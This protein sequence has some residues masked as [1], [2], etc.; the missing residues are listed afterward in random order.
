MSRMIHFFLNMFI[1]LALL[2]TSALAHGQDRSDWPAHLTLLTSPAGG[3][4]FSLGPII[5][6]VLNN[7]LLP[8]A[9]RAGKGV[10]NINRISQKQGDIAFTLSCFLNGGLSG[11]EEYKTLETENVRIIAN[12]YP[13]ILYVL[14][15]KDFAKKHN[16]TNVSDLLALKEPV[17]FASLRQGTSSEFI[18]KILL[19][20]GYNTSFKQLQAQGW[21][22][23][24][25]KFAE[26]TDN[27]VAGKLDCF[28]YTAGTT[29]PLIK[30]MEKHIKITILPIEKKVLSLLSE[31]F[32]TD[33]YIIES[34]DYNAI[35]KPTPTLSTYATL[36]VNKDLPATLVHE[37]LNLIFQNKWH[38]GSKI[39]DFTTL[40]PDTAIPESLPMHPA[41]L[42]FWNNMKK[43]KHP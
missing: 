4:W 26:I 32:K 8:T 5:A 25:G 30:E 10:D 35:T 33:T 43:V 37:V 9:S 1:V 36:I 17:R 27:F 34:G 21:E 19:Q 31:K 20:Y 23:L 7:D 13:Q 15:R 40:S 22:I 41:A 28:T 29:V 24:F 2:S 3:Q 42:K 14:L 6:D 11:S 16:I 39:I 38:I 12:V 18:L